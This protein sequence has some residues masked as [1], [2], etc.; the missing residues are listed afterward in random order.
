[1]AGAFQAQKRPQIMFRNVVED[2]SPD[3]ESFAVLQ[4]SPRTTLSVLRQNF[5]DGI[6]Y[7]TLDEA[8]GCIERPQLKREA[9]WLQCISLNVLQDARSPCREVSRI[10]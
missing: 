8:E 5:H 9:A 2:S 6:E 4:M 1:M 7:I 10:R 3:A